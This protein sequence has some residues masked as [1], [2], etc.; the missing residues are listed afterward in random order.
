MALPKMRLFFELL[1]L[2][3]SQRPITYL[4][5]YVQ[6]VS[7][8]LPTSNFRHLLTCKYVMRRRSSSSAFACMSMQFLARRSVAILLNF[9]TEGE[10][11]QGM[12]LLNSSRASFRSCIRL[13][14]LAFMFNR[15]SF[16]WRDLDLLLPLPAL[17]C[18]PPPLTA[19]PSLRLSGEGEKYYFGVNIY[20]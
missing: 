17:A 3:K 6:T 14:S 12:T 5:N 8:F 16:P 1:K 20:K 10:C 7:P 18:P 9:L 15:T 19:L 11:A 13:L 4:N 2:S